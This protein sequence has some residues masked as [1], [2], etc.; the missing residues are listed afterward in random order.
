M[1]TS[2]RSLRRVFVFAVVPAML[3]A[4][5]SAGFYSAVP[6]P[7]LQTNAV[8]GTGSLT[9]TVTAP[10]P[11]K[12]AQVYIR[13][14]QKR[15]LY[16][17]FTE[18]GRFRA[19][20]LLPG[21]YEVSVRAKGLASGVQKLTIR[22]GESPRLTLAMQPSDGEPA[23]LDLSLQREL[24]GRTAM[25][26]SG[27]GQTYVFESYDQIYPPGPGKAV[28]EQVCM[29][30]HGEN[31][32]PTRPA[33]EAVWK[34]RIDHMTG[35]GLWERDPSSYAQGLLSPRSNDFHFS[36][37]DETEL[38]AYL[39][40]NF[41]PDK[42]PRAVRTEREMPLD[43]SK[44]GKAMFIEYYLAE[45][46]PGQGTN[47][48]EFANIRARYGQD[49][50][51]DNDGNVWLT[52]RGVP[53]RLVKLDPRTGEQKEYL[54]PDPK[55]GNH[56]V[57]IDRDGLIWL[58][59]HS[60]QTPSKEKRLLGFNPK[61]EKFEHII[62]MDPENVVRSPIKWLQ[63]LAMD[64]KGNIYVGWIMGGAI[65]K[66][67]RATGL[68]SVHRIPTPKAI[69]Y[70]VVADRNDNIWV[71]YW[72]GGK[73]GKF[74]PSTN[75]WTEFAAPTYPGHVR[76]LNVDSKN[77]IWFGIW[78]AGR[79]PGKLVKLDQ[80]T[81]RMTEWSIPQQNA[82][83]YDVSADRDDNIWIVDSPTPDRA[84]AL[85]KFDTR[86]QAFTFYPKPQFSADTPKIQVTAQGSIW[87]SPRGSRFAPGYG[88]LYP[89]MDKITTLGAYYLNGAPGYPF[90]VAGK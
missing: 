28:A 26:T 50:R 21:E 78:A 86:D 90:K 3:L 76:R 54:Y 17:V 4:A 15:M 48:P 22:A 40:A 59:E 80:T 34:S 56:E 81:G 12:A 45:D 23:A 57:L 66:W 84:A 9:G 11:F 83:P 33:T 67:D 29:V 74:D 62:P 53:H 79:R 19:M 7:P 63:S 24:A 6:S 72:S 73:I 75:G 38:L 10:M 32:L 1:E 27:A 87:Y 49:V 5:G 69:P 46:P 35:R 18:A 39:V 25:D 77:N 51:F 89:D 43:E 65:S 20:A 60:G 31:F 47:A 82:Q 70:G 64:S 44:L 13:N 36:R 55:N 2:S 68:V 58:P 14:A 8:R 52:D 71:A 61:T 37:Q 85:A 30:C 88:V 41:G 42:K 16:M